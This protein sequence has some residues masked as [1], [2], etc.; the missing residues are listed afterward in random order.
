LYGRN[1]KNDPNEPSVSYS[2]DV[3]LTDDMYADLGAP[4]PTPPTQRY[5]YLKLQGVSK[6]KEIHAIDKCF[7]NT[8]VPTYT[9]FVYSLL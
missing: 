4:S 6:T 7:Q 9:Y 3:D 5:V 1:R 8:N 2:R